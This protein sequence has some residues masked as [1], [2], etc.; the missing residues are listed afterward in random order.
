MALNT[1]C[2]FPFLRML[3][4]MNLKDEIKA[5]FEGGQQQGDLSDEEFQKKLNAKG[6]DFLF[7]LGEK[8]PDAENEF[9]QFMAAYSGKSIEELQEMEIFEL[10]DMMKGI[11]Q[12]PRLSGFFQ[13]AM[14]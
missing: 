5:L 7:L 14:K 11:F 1:K 4:K 8:I 3:K 13:Q 6:F 12:D 10:F 9:Y 2:F